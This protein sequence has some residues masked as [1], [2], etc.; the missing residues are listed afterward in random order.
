MDKIDKELTIKFKSDT[1]EIKQDLSKFS[2]ELQGVVSGKMGSGGGASAAGMGR[3]IDDFI[4]KS[5]QISK[6]LTEGGSKFQQIIKNI[7]ENDLQKLETK[8]TQQLN[9]FQQRFRELERMTVAGET[10]ERIRRMQSVVDRSGARASQSMLEYNRIADQSMGIPAGGGAGGGI[11]GG[12]GGGGTGSG[13]VGGTPSGGMGNLGVIIANALKGIGL[14]AGGVQQSAQMY[15][16]YVRT[17]SASRAQL[18]STI[19]ARRQAIMEGDFTLPAMEQQFG[20]LSR[21][22]DVSQR[23]TR[24]EDIR[25]VASPLAMGLGAYGATALTMGVLGVGAAAAA[26]L[27]ATAAAGYG[28][29][30]AGKYFLSG[31]REA[32]RQRAENTE[33]ENERQ[34]NAEYVYHLQNVQRR[35]RPRF[36]F[37]RQTQMGNNDF[38]SFLR[39]GMQ[40]YVDEGQL[41]QGAL[42]FRSRFG[43][44]DASGMALDAARASRA[45]NITFQSAQNLLGAVAMTGG[46]QA[47]AQKNLEDMFSRAFTR[48][49]SDSGM[50]ETIANAVAT[51]AQ[52]QTLPINAVRMMERLSENLN[53]VT[54][55]ASPTGR[56]LAGVS[57]SEGFF[58][59]LGQRGGYVGAMRALRLTSA[60][61]PA[62]AQ[63]PLVRSRLMGM[64]PEEMSNIQN[65]PISQQ[66]FRQLY[67]EQGARERLSDIASNSRRELIDIFKKT[68]QGTQTF[69][70]IQ[71]AIQRGDLETALAFAAGGVQA[72]D[73]NRSMTEAGA[74][75]TAMQMLQDAAPGNT[76]LTKLLEQRQRQSDQVANTRRNEE[77]GVTQ[78]QAQQ[79]RSA[80]R[81]QAES[82]VLSRMRGRALRSWE[83]Q[84]KGRSGSSMTPVPNV[85]T[86][87]FS[88]ADQDEVQ[89]LME[90]DF[91]NR[92]RRA[93]GRVAGQSPVE[94][95]IGTGVERLRGEQD[96]A[97]S[98]NF[99]ELGEQ[100]VN[101]IRQGQ[102][103][104]GGLSGS[105]DGLVEAL[106]NFKNELSN[107][108]GSSPFGVST[109]GN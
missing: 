78:E 103:V 51:R 42:G 55:G 22:R 71:G 106:N 34:R 107:Q 83:E 53:L 58:Q 7:T 74:E 76:E 66:I 30:S 86:A 75:I 14:V 21:S 59:Q 26:P 11:G 16:D 38:Y 82:I 69:Q 100:G 5:S 94:A 101:I 109:S 33:M 57:Q 97:S 3:T 1:S 32:F 44:S 19:F 6:T 68:P 50:R 20:S 39:T 31:E 25:K 54:G 93:G 85:T 43:A 48:G 63:D 70:Q 77:M 49:I 9:R 81:S 27:A 17:E 90:S 87:D 67:G 72:I 104:Q 73:P 4:K 29:Y 84:N 28:I 10:P 15:Q 13:A 95:A 108:S 2:S 64:T 89:R 91:A 92:L 12:A 45:Q 102:S 8:A 79:M 36:E 80:S 47:N 41:I 105:V 61:G 60:M 23:I 24:A 98:T 65:D 56:Q 52:E 40:N 96:V 18:A 62:A 35:A 37:A 88:E 46:D 99:R